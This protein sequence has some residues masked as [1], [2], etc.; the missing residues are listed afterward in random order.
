[1]LKERSSHHVGENVKALRE[2]SVAH[3]EVVVGFFISSVG[4]TVASSSQYIVEESI[5]LLVFLGAKEEAVLKIVGLA[6]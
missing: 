5:F 2:G 4:I 6:W 1:M 3:R